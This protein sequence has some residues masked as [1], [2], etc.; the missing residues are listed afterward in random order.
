MTAAPFDDLLTDQSGLRTVYRSPAEPALRK[1]IDHLDDHCRSFIAHSPI[2]VL[3]TAGADGRCDASPKGG[4]PGFVVVLDEH[5]LAIPDLSG[6]NRLDSLSNLVENPF[7]ALLFLIPG[8][9]E[10]LRVNGRAGV[11]TDETVLEACS[12]HDKRPKAAIGIEVET[13]YIHCA[14]ALKRGEVWQPERWP[15]LA[16]LPSPACMLSDHMALP[17]LTPE[18]VESALAESYATRLWA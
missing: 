12:V 5:R 7:V 14:K 17:D 6:N 15:D 2:L 16:D 11:T 10:T 8:V 3:S 18:V 13:A 1:E 9:D 4:P